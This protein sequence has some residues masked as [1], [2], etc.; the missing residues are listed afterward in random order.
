[1]F[2]SLQVWVEFPQNSMSGFN[3]LLLQGE[4]KQAEEA[5]VTRTHANRKKK[6]SS[7]HIINV[8]SFN[9]LHLF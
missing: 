9:R 7:T 2:C 3:V 6:V 8:K 1:M 5:I 4:D